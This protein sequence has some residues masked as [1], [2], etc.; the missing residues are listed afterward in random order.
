M[1]IVTPGMVTVWFANGTVSPPNPVKT[2]VADRFRVSDEVVITL[3]IAGA[4]PR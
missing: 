4:S 3:A 2:S 1:G